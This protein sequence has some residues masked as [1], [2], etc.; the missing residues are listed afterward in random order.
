MVT[1]TVNGEMR[2]YEEGTAYETIAKEYQKQYSS[3]IALVTVNGK[4]R[5]LFKKVKK[6]CEVSFFTSLAGCGR[7]GKPGK[8]KS[9]ICHRA[10][11]LLQRKRGCYTEPGIYRQAEWADEGTGRGRPSV[12][13]KILSH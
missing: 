2:E 3:R 5:E 6:D 12:Y 1:V 7:E 4:I 13:K 10:G 8:G 9:R 11:L